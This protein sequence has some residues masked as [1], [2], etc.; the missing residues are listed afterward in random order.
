MLITQGE[1]LMLLDGAIDRFDVHKAHCLMLVM[2]WRWSSY[3]CDNTIPT[4]QNIQVNLRVLGNELW[5][6]I[7]TC[8]GDEYFGISS[9]GFEVQ[10]YRRSGSLRIAFIPVEV[11][12]S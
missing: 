11:R 12:S 2:N 5:K 9:G 3:I 8:P 6:E 1:F 4:E 10:Y 7:E